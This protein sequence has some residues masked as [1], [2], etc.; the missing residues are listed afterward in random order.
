MCALGDRRIRVESSDRGAQQGQSDDDEQDGGAQCQPD[1]VESCR[2]RARPVPRSHPFRHARSRGIGEEDHQTEHRLQ[3]RRGDCQRSQSTGT[4][5]AHHGRVREQKN[6]FGDQGSEC[7]KSQTENVLVDR[8]H[9][10]D[11]SE[12]RR[13][14]RS[15]WVDG[16][17]L[18][19]RS[20]SVGGSGPEV[21]GQLRRRSTSAAPTTIEWRYADGPPIAKNP[22]A[23]SC[24]CRTV[25]S[26]DKQ[27]STDSDSSESVT[28]G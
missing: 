3:D 19:G 15:I 25:E 1:S 23:M 21:R 2:D 8:C 4:E 16:L 7:G 24:Q 20:I 22:I 12:P 9:V 27:I 28:I 10:P 11:S 26:E 17:G 13:W 6:G 18:R 14:S 5:V